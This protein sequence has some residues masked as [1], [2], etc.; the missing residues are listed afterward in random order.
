M[1]RGLTNGLVSVV[2]VSWNSAGFLRRCLAA[3]A[4]QT[5][6]AIELIHIDNASDDDSVA[7]VRE[8]APRARQII[9][10]ANR[11]F[12]AA[13]NQGVRIAGGSLSSF[14]ILMRF[15]IRITWRSSSMRS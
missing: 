12:S 4:S 6:D 11:G 13:V 10:D 9:N 1:E 5:Y 14:S 2:I 15:S 3:L 7:I 8:A